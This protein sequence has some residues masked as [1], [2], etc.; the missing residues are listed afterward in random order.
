MLYDGDRVLGG[1]WIE[2]T[3]S[4]ELELGLTAGQRVEQQAEQEQAAEHRPRR[5][6]RLRRGPGADQQPAG[7]QQRDADARRS[8]ALR[9]AAGNAAMLADR[10]TGAPACSTIASQTKLPVIARQRRRVPP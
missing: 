5:P 1:G 8:P 2:E 3:V 6:G 7:H 9:R 4:A 10:R